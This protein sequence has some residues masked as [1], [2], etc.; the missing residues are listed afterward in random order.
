MDF[1]DWNLRPTVFK[2]Q[3]QVIIMVGIVFNK[4]KY[5]R[6]GGLAAAVYLK[7]NGNFG[8]KEECQV[9]VLHILENFCIHLY[10]SLV[11]QGQCINE[12]VYF[13]KRVYG[14]LPSWKFVTSLTTA[15]E[16]G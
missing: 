4:C 13:Y 2:P 14:G 1:G 15:T 6:M 16:R 11:L 5:F 12:Y 9:I 8:N 7:T 3:V 10:F